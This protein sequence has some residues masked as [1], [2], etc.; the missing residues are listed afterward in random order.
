MMP[1]QLNISE[2]SRIEGA[3]LDFSSENFPSGENDLDFTGSFGS[4]PGDDTCCVVQVFS[5]K[6]G[7][8]HTTSV[9]MSATIHPDQAE[10]R[11]V[12]RV[13]ADFP[14]NDAAQSFDISFESQIQK[15]ILL[16]LPAKPS[17]N[18]NS[19]SSGGQSC[20]ASGVVLIAATSHGI[21]I[22]SVVLTREPPS[23]KFQVAAMI[24][25]RRRIC[26]WIELLCP[27]IS[28]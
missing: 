17:F 12:L 22:R 6:N 23:E 3:P 24:K 14:E 20:E 26:V 13:D 5:S 2:Y 25:V 16:P 8:R 21:H 18:K 11:V 19:N 7:W 27:F 10:K 15:I 9:S 4:A 28:S 1:R